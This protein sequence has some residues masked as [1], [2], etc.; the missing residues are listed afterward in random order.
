MEVDAWLGSW[1]KLCWRPN[2]P[3][4]KYWCEHG[5]PRSNKEWSCQILSETLTQ[6]LGMQMHGLCTMHNVHNDQNALEATCWYTTNASY[7]L[8][9]HVSMQFNQ[10]KCLSMHEHVLKDARC[11]SLWLECKENASVC[12]LCMKILTPTPITLQNPI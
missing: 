12:M 5:I 4:A 2:V 11:M 9:H 8:I 1:C 3:H 7:T 6:T 10:A